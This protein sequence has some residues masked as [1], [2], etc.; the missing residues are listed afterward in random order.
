VCGNPALAIKNM[1]IG[2]G[3]MGR[4]GFQPQHYGIDLLPA[5]LHDNRSRDL[6]MKPIGGIGV[7]HCLDEKSGPP[8]T[9]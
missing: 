9:F 6:K 5:I 8:N 2:D 1:H 3:C 7:A 4:S